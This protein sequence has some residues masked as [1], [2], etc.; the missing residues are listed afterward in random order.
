[1]F[2]YDKVFFL[3]AR[4]VGLDIVSKEIKKLKIKDISGQVGA[5]KAELHQ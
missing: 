3:T 5:V 2:I 4:D 1:M